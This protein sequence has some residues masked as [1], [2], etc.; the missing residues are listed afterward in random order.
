MRLIT[1]YEEVDQASSLI[2]SF[3]GLVS[4]SSAVYWRFMSLHTDTLC[5]FL[6]H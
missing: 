5:V 3:C 1:I 4:D 2:T 6:H